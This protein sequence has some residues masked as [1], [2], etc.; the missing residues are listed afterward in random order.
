[1]AETGEQP[2]AIWQAVDFPA[3][4]NPGNTDARMALGLTLIDAGDYSEAESVLRRALARED[5]HLGIRNRTEFA[6]S[7]S[8]TLAQMDS[9]AAALEVLQKVETEGDGE[10]N[11]AILIEFE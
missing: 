9:S 11:G 1:M 4:I 3:R 2:E 6:I 5:V 8:T 10:L 7:L